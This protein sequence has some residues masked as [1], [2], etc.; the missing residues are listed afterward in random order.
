MNLYVD[1]GNSRI[2]WLASAGRSSGFPYRSADL[3][4]ELAVQWAGLEPPETVVVANVAGAEVAA[5]V[6][7]FS[8]ANWGLE[9]RYL[10]VAD[11]FGDLVNAYE[12]CRQMGIDRW[13]AMIAARSAYGGHLCVI[14]IGTAV[15]VDLVLDDGRHQGGYILPGPGLMQELLNRH[16]REINV[17]PGVCTDLSPGRST[18]SCLRNGVYLAV[19]ALIERVVR[20]QED[21]CGTAFRCIITGGGAG[22]IRDLL[23][24]PTD[25]E[26]ELVLKGMAIVSG[27][28]A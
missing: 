24:L 7:R 10:E 27:D 9:P 14:D 28:R 8:R 22:V 25:H 17:E 3:P 6:D 26:P 16:A 15:T 18:A 23:A 12:D 5:V 1:I 4:Q 21:R 2:K 20:E 11:R 19:T 13:L